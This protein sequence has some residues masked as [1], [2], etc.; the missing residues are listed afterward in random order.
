LVIQA[1]SRESLVARTR[2]LDRVLL[3]GHYVIPQWHLRFQRILYWNKFSR[4]ETTSKDGTSTT[5][6]WYDADKA[7]RLKAARAGDQ[8]E[9]SRAPQDTEVHTVEVE[10]MRR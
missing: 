7:A 8:P 4:P 5:Y 6:W 3:H 9:S 10:E 2:A 1:S